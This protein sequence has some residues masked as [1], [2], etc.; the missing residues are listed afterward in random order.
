MGWRI[1][2]VP[3]ECRVHQPTPVLSASQPLSRLPNVLPLP[4]AFGPQSAFSKV[5]PRKCPIYVP[6]PRCALATILAP[7]GGLL[8]R[9]GQP[10]LERNDGRTHLAIGNHLLLHCWQSLMG[11]SPRTL[12][13]RTYQRPIAWAI[14]AS[15]MV[16]ILMYVALVVLG[17]A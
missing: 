4:G 13:A 17:F 7:R 10:R 5:D 16:F 15:V 14:F 8:H 9:S 11:S 12:L 3:W 2:G 6:V 1:A